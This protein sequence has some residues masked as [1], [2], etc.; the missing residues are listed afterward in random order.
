MRNDG[1]EG[2]WLEN[3]SRHQTEIYGSE[4]VEEKMDG[5]GCSKSVLGVEDEEA[6]VR[7]VD[8]SGS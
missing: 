6:E 5:R 3:A 7:T 8:L 1:K 2:L 4:D